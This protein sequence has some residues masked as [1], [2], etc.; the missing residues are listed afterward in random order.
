[1]PKKRKNATIGYPQ[2]TSNVNNERREDTRDL[3]SARW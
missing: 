1:M 2:E 3:T